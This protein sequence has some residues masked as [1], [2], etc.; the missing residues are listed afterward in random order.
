M[1]LEERETTGI[2]IK[3]SVILMIKQIKIREKNHLMDQNNDK[4]LIP[5]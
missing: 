2:K 3:I 4:I 5:W 1:I